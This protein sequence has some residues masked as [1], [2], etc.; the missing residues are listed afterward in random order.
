[1]K[2]LSQ[3]LYRISTGV[4]ALVFTGI[5]LSF[6]LLALP[7]QAQQA[8]RNANGGKS[9]DTTFLYSP[10]DLYRMADRHGAAGRAGYIRARFTFDLVFPLVY[11]AFLVAA[12]SWLL[13][14]LIPPSSRWRLLNLAPLAGVLFDFLENT[15]AS[16]VMLRY[17]A[18]TPL[19]ALAAPV[20]TFIKW[21]FVAGSFLLLIAS[22]LLR[23]WKA[24]N[25]KSI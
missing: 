25:K 6:S 23:A 14:G 24:L 7:P 13:G 18:E 5:F 1:M 15:A 19:A 9:P 11:G 8:Q 3:W 20:F 4:V 22:A 2:R 21:L 16:L 17:P 10:A 12:L